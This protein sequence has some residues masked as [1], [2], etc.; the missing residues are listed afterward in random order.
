M[1]FR[2][3]ATSS[4]CPRHG[5]VW[6]VLSDPDFV[7]FPNSEFVEWLTMV[8]VSLTLEKG[9]I[10]C[11]ALWAIWGERNSR[12]HDKTSSSGQEIARFVHS[13][14]RELD[15]VRKKTQNL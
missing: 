10:F 2:I 11:V 3:L 8:L 9:R 7:M 6:R 1:T 14:L 12:I 4:L 13:Y 15:G 5:G